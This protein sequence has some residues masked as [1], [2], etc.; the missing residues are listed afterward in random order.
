MTDI[1]KVEMSGPH[2]LGDG[3]YPVRPIIQ[4]LTDSVLEFGNFFS[5]Q[6][7]NRFGP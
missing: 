7:P 5:T 3:R 4:G 2:V 6:G 1:P